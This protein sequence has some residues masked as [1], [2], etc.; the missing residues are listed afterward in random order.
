MVFLCL[1]LFFVCVFVNIV[2]SQTINLEENTSNYAKFNN[3]PLEFDFN[4][5]VDESMKNFYGFVAVASA[6][7][8]FI[9]NSTTYSGIAL[10]I[11]STDVIDEKM[12]YQEKQ[13]CDVH[14]SIVDETTSEIKK[15][16]QID[17]NCSKQY[18]DFISNNL[19]KKKMILYESLAESRPEYI[20]KSPQMLSKLQEASK[21]IDWI[22]YDGTINL[23]FGEIPIKKGQI[24]C[25]IIGL[26]SYPTDDCHLIKAFISETIYGTPY[27]IKNRKS[28]VIL[29][30]LYTRTMLI[31]ALSKKYQYKSYLEIGCD[32]N[33]TFAV[34]ERLKFTKA[35][36]VDPNT[37]GTLRMTSDDY[38]K[39]NHDKALKNDNS[40]DMFDIIFIDGLHEEHQAYVDVLN[41]LKYLNPGGTIVMHDLYPMSE[42]YQTFPMQTPMWNGDT[43]KAAVKLRLHHDIEIIVGDFDHGVGIIRKRENK[44]RLPIEWE[45]R[46][47]RS[48]FSY[49]NTYKYIGAGNEMTNEII[50]T[51]DEK[52]L[53]EYLKE[54]AQY[55]LTYND[56]RDNVDTLLRLKT[57]EEIIQWLDEE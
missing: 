41:S 11:S 10:M 32:K 52:V 19:I 53:K 56:L 37:G 23:R 51:M 47:T 26:S 7:E 15:L 43:W 34:M 18:W 16:S 36:C 46:L 33:Q 35:L 38:F 25:D 2:D 48:P 39:I 12:R 8:N 6:Q 3:I 30:Q 54:Q 4:R 31:E 44:N 27:Y 22:N 20:D 21:E 14:S 13:I 55:A 28:A 49:S 50:D 17:E 5:K 57:L 9:Y 1:F 45:T 42:I 29:D 40:H 24:L